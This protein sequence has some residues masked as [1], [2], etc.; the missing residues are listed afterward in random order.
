MMICSLYR[1]LI[2]FAHQPHKIPLASKASYYHD[3]F[4]GRF[5][6]SGDQYDKSDFT[7]AHR[8]L[9]FNSILLVTNTLN[10]KSVVVRVND[11]G[12][13]NKRRVVDLSRAAAMK[14]GMIP[15][16]VVPVK[17]KL[18]T[19]L[20]RLSTTDSILSAG[21]SWNCF[22]SKDS[23]NGSSIQIWETKNWKHAF[24][25][26]SALQ[27]ENKQLHFVVKAGSVNGTKEYQLVIT[28]LEEK[29]ETERLLSHFRTAG[30]INA[31]ILP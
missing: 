14:V 26:A 31:M 8:T 13:F 1:P 9:P 16:G 11:R 20:D 7:V 19:L 17:V 10:H 24:Y 30:F 28:H 23:L 12:P 25:M 15:F 2:S 29:K 18:L 21:S 3:K 27:L 22:A 6:S 4:E 5:T